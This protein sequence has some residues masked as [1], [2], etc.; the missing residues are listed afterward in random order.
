M[1][2]PV[3]GGIDYTQWKPLNT[4]SNTNGTTNTSSILNSKEKDEFVSSAKGETCT[5]GKDDGKI[6]LLD[7]VGNIAKGGVNT[8]VNG[9]KGMFTDSEGN[10]SLGKT[11]LSAGVAAACIAFPAVGLALCGVGAVTGAIKMGKG[12]VTANSAK[13]DAEA[14][15]AWQDV[16]GGAVT[17]GLSVAG[18]KG[19]FSAMK[20]SASATEAG[21]ALESLE[22]NAS[23]AEKAGA[24]LN[25][26]RNSTTNNFSTYK[27]NIL[28]KY[29]LNSLIDARTALKEAK[30]S[31][32]N[33]AI[34]DR[35]SVV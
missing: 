16:G 31:G 26:A 11:L 15:A 30:K 27:N 25:D 3:T 28:N 33:E 20:T 35:K 19:S 34:T 17:T 23:I 32:D 4:A 14:K 12:I 9:V 2:I 5:D 22:E 18:A 8:L 7:V 21:S 29:D 1:S 10:F 6:G 13:T 24:L